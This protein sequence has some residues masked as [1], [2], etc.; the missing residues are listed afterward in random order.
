MDNDVD[1]SV[2]QSL[3]ATTLRKRLEN[4]EFALSKFQR[5]ADLVNKILEHIDNGTIDAYCSKW[6]ECIR[7]S[8]VRIELIK[9]AILLK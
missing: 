8:K 2:F 6:T 3:D 1:L 4:A 9:M 5:H 7:E